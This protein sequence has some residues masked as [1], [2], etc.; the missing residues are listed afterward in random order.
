MILRRPRWLGRDLQLLFA[1]RALRSVSQSYLAVIVPLY[2]AHL[3]YGPV[4]IGVFFTVGAL[5]SM[6][7]TA[8]VGFLADR[9]GRKALLVILGVLTAVCGLAFVFTQQ[10]AILLVASGLGA[11]GRGGGA[12]SGGAFGPY[13]PAEQ[14][15]IAEH[16]GDHYRTTAFSVVAVVGVIAA[17]LGSLLATTPTLLHRATGMADVEAER[18]LFLLTTVLGLAMALVVLPLR[19]SPRPVRAPGTR[20]HLAHSTWHVL[21]RLFVTNAANGLAVGMLGPIMV[22]WF[23]VR[24]DATSGQLGTLF[25]LANVVAVPTNFAAARVARRLGTVKAIVTARSTSVTL[26]AIMALMPN[27]LLAAIFFLLRTQANTLSSPMRQSYL[28]GVVA[29]DDRSTAAG[30]STL[31]TQALSTIGPTVAGQL[32]EMGWLSL[33]LELAA[34]LQG[35]STLLYYTFFRNILPPEEQEPPA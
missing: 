29:E 8:T 16:A 15:L 13:A 31:P 25:F 14:A 9:F 3:G 23:H 33:P 22:Y 6:S 24:Y 1:G 30:L 17:A 20:H 26:L 27:F 4:R 10:F 2:L 7:L 34:V 11:I 21:V 28:M 5:G 18:G 19:E 35:V 12:G 32:M